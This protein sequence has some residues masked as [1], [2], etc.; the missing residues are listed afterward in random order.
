M[1]E[2]TYQLPTLNG[3]IPV[4]VAITGLPN[5]A[6][7]AVAQ[8]ADT[9]TQQLNAARAEKRA[10]LRAA[11]SV[12]EQQHTGG[13]TISETTRLRLA[14]RSEER[15]RPHTAELYVS[16][17]TQGAVV[18]FL[19]KEGHLPSGNHVVSLGCMDA[20][21]GD[22]TARTAAAEVIAE[23]GFATV[24]AG[25]S[26]WWEHDDDTVRIAI[27]PTAA[28]LAYVARRYGPLPDIPET[29]GLT[30][31][32]TQR[33]WWRVDG[34]GPY[35]LTWSPAL[36]GDWWTVWGGVAYEGLGMCPSR[37]VARTCDLTQ[38]I[39]AIAASK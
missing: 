17:I 11:Y 27:T 36:N 25:G 35:W 22:K 28:Y 31:E 1:A 34:A 39:E 24:T 15:T 12:R 38:A 16:P 10:A 3:T 30:F 7:V 6:A 21:P 5:H 32:A 37:F 18:R 20:G 4:T 19:D 9:L 26:A 2:H 29:A 33:G 8:Y 13:T 23:R 14:R